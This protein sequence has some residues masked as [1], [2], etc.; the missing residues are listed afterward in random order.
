MGSRRASSSFSRMATEHRWTLRSE[1]YD[2][3]LERQARVGREDQYNADLESFRQR[4]K[5][6]GRA[7]L[8]CAVNLLNKAN[9]ALKV[10]EQEKITP[11]VIS[12][13]FRAAAAVALLASNLEASSLGVESLI[14]D[15]I[16]QEDALIDA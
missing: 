4:Q 2:A 11:S 7:S 14:R 15:M 5:S 16:N 13:M 10:L 12:S 6:L 9:D 3:H 1:A 8:G